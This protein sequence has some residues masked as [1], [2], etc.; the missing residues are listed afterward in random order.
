M[1]VEEEEIDEESDNSNKDPTI[2]K[3]PKVHRDKP[4]EQRKATLNCKMRNK[5]RIPLIVKPD[6][7]S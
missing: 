1:E 4:K 3:E 7:M 6:C 5:T 2:P